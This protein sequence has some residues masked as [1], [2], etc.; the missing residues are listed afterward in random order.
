MAGTVNVTVFRHAKKK[1]NLVIEELIEIKV[2][3]YVT[4]VNTRP[5]QVI[6]SFKKDIFQGLTANGPR[7]ETVVDG[8]GTLTLRS[9]NR[10]SE[11]GYSYVF[12]DS[13]EDD[14]IG[15]KA[16]VRKKHKKK[17]KARKRAAGDDPRII[18]G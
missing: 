13:R 18:I 7:F 15:T 3:D 12:H 5:I 16:K 11:T 4:F 10:T 9:S 6:L 1:K 17:A 14:V 8:D 2:G